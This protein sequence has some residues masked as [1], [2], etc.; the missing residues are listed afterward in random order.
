MYFKWL[1]AF[2]NVVLCRG[3]QYIED[4]FE[5][6]VGST[7]GCGLFIKGKASLTLSGWNEIFVKVA[8]YYA[9]HFVFKLAPYKHLTRPPQC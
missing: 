2:C 6:D 1:G 7:K 4:L 8:Y 9:F 5:A 3:I